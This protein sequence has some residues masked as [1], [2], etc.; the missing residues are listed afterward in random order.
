LY[1]GVS[2]MLVLWLKSYAPPAR[3]MTGAQ[4]PQSQ[5]IIG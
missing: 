4:Q 2:G 1:L 3:S 5:E